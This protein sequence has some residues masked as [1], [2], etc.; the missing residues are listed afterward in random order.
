VLTEIGKIM[1]IDSVTQETPG[2]FEHHTTATKN[3]F[4]S[5]TDAEMKD[6]R[7]KADELLEKGMP[8]DVKRK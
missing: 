1:G 4:N 7:K 5:M 2:W 3:I 8:E 6:L